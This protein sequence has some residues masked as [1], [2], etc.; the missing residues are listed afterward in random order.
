MI[1]HIT[2]VDQEPVIYLDADFTETFTVYNITYPNGVKTRT[3]FDYT[4]YTAKAQIRKKSDSP[5]ALLTF[6]TDDYSID[7]T[8]GVIT[9][10]KAKADINAS[11]LQSDSRYVWDLVIIDS[12]GNE[13]VHIGGYIQVKNTVTEV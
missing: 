7:L 8:D 6:S 10:T 9:L 3:L 5:T 12:D 1:N 2:N 4:G 11:S 13:Y